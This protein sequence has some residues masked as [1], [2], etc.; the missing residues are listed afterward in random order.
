MGIRHRAVFV[1]MILILLVAVS[2]SWATLGQQMASVEHDRSVMS[3][4]RQSKPATGY[5]IETITV[6][7][8][9]V[10]EYVSTNGVVFAVTWS[11]VGMP[12]LSLLF[13]SYFEEYQEGVK[14]LQNQKPRM[15]GPMA[16]KTS[17]L[18]VERVGHTRGMWGRAFVPALLPATV[19]PQDIQ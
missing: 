16:L 5:S 7:G 18:I 15:R 17:H 1:M 3:G 13:G 4:H 14:A 8:M 9:T 12:D 6:A 2:Q 11:G 19:S 10:N